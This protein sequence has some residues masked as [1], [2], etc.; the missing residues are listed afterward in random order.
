[1]AV[2]VLV[3]ALQ[4]GLV[5]VAIWAGGRAVTGFVS[6]MAATVTFVL[7]IVGLTLPNSPLQIGTTQ[8]AFVVGMGTDGTIV[9]EAVAASLVYTAFLILPIMLAGSSLV[10][11]GYLGAGGPWA[12]TRKPD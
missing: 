1:M 10:L 3:S 4:W 2:A 5:W 6:P 12:A 7:I 8:L 9:S 11:R